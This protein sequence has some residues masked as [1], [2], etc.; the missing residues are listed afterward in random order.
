MQYGKQQAPADERGYPLCSLP[1]APAGEGPARA[2][3]GADEHHPC[4]HDR[5]PALLQGQRQLPRQ[6]E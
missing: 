1:A 5:R 4:G 2:A 3:G 6:G